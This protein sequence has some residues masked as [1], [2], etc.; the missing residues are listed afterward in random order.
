MLD[1]YIGE[2]TIS[3]INI[4]NGIEKPTTCIKFVI[5]VIYLVGMSRLENICTPKLSFGTI[6]F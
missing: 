1:Q 6:Q 4:N 3:T 5:L 2:C